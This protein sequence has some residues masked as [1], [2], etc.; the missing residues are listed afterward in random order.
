M[1]NKKILCSTG[2]LVGRA[3]GFDHTLIAR[4]GGSVCADGFE[5]MMLKAYYD[6]LDEVRRT[7]ER[8]AIPVYTIHF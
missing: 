3:N 1:M 5:L 4:Y 8:A 7:V 6:C 2:T